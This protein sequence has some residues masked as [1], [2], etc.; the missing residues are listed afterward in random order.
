MDLERNP[1][2]GPVTEMA[3]DVLRASG[4]STRVEP[5][6]ERYDV[7]MAENDFGLAAIVSAKNWTD[8]A[9]DLPELQLGLA[10]WAA[11]RGAGAK[12]WDLYLVIL[13]SDVLQDSDLAAATDAATD[14][15]MVRKIIRAGV[16]PDRVD[17]RKALAPLLPLGGPTQAEALAPLRELEARLPTHGLTSEQALSAI[18]AFLA[19][20]PNRSDDGSGLDRD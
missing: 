13:V 4:F 19:A 7:L 9:K 20:A 14:L 15:R 10:N 8:V 3:E 12:Q 17:V 1:T 2:L 11:E 6:G 5:V 16:P 18:A